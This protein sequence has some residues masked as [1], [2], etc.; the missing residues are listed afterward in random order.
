MRKFNKH[1][2][3]LFILFFALCSAHAQDNIPVRSLPSEIFVTVQKASKDT[4]K[5]RWKRGGTGNL[6]LSQSSQ[7]DWAAGG[8][9]F[10]MSINTY[11]NAFLYYRKNKNTWDNNLDFNFGYMQATSTGGRKND[12]R[13]AVT[14]KYGYKI[15]SSGKLL[16]SFLVNGRSQLFDGRQYFTKDSSQLISS[17]LSPAYG[18]TSAGLDYQPDNA[19]SIFASPLTARL[20]VVLKESLA[21]KNLY[22]IGTHR[23]K[24]APGAFV[25][26]NYNKEIMKNINYKANLNL[27]SDYTHNA[28][29]VDMDM[30]NYINF[31]I[32]KYI[33]ATYS[34][35]LMYDDDIKLFGP[36]SNS[37]GLQLQSQIGIGFSMPFKTG[38]TRI[39]M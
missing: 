18:V 36:N 28:Q 10:A 38:Y 9:N 5:W 26:I 27:F 20:T 21:Q 23:Y 12:D 11:V 33:S 8:D 6:N 1:L 34:L 29:D 25:A 35:N 19:L 17:F 16:A 24:V 22:G 37:P 30:S 15:D 31:K 32:N 2:Y 7:R 4:I 39:S 13:I 14:T 3:L